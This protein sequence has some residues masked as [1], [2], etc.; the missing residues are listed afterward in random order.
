MLF[1][2]NDRIYGCVLVPVIILFFAYYTV[3]IFGSPFLPE[4]HEQSG[5]FFDR[6]LAVEVPITAGV[7]LLCVLGLFIGGVFIMSPE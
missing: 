5:L 7:G 3:W 1:L 2:G 6:M 4:D